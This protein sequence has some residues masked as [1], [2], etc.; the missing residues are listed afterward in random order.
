MRQPRIFDKKV[1]D[2]AKKLPHIMP[3]PFIALENY[4][5]TRR[6]KRWDN[7][8]RVNFTI[9]QAIYSAFRKYCGKEGY[10]MS[11]MVERLIK[12]IVVK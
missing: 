12:T 3:E 6:L 8:V 2:L 7:K 5:R 1:F 4:D 10:K 9:D 11:T